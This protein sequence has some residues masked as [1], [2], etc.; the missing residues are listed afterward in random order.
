MANQHHVNFIQYI[1]DEDGQEHLCLTYRCEL[2]F[3]PF[4]G[5][6][7][8]VNKPFLEWEFQVEQV[9]W[10]ASSNPKFVCNMKKI[11][12]SPNELDP[13][14]QSIHSFIEI[15]NYFKEMSKGSKE[16]GERVTLD[17]SHYNF[18]E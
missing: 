6:M 10:T 2:D 5:M 14:W 7:I 4:V 16:W 17:L 3:V 8:S 11:K 18:R 1:F 13:H 15:C 12:Y 9:L